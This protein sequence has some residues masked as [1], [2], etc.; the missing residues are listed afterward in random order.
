LS[1]SK[2]LLNQEET[3]SKTGQLA[4]TFYV[5]HVI[6]A[7]IN[8]TKIGSYSIE[9]SFLY[10]ILFCFLCVTFAIIW[11]NNSKVGPLEWVMRK[12]TE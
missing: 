10:A 11:T 2:L 9:I 8:P 7:E 12:I 5:A 3:L 1:I 4:L 6:I